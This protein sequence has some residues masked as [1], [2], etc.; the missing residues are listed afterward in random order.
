MEG[1]SDDTRI[2]CKEK[3][4]KGKILASALQT[5][6]VSKFHDRYCKYIN[7][8]SGRVAK[9]KDKSPNDFCVEFF[10]DQ[11]NHLHS[12]VD[13]SHDQL[14]QVIKECEKEEK[15]S[16]VVESQVKQPKENRFE[17]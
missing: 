15:K 13:T 16:F 9:D 6:I 10:N 3:V 4:R 2:T 17:L 1:G 7:Y 8:A 14:L 5:S 12:I 11:G